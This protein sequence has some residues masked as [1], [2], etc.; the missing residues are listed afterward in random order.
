MKRKIILFLIPAFLICFIYGCSSN[1]ESKSTIN[2]T[3]TAKDTSNSTS[4]LT[5]IMIDI[6][7]G[8]GSDYIKRDT[9]DSSKILSIIREDH[10]WYEVEC[11]SYGR[12]YVKKDMITDADDSEIPLVTSNIKQGPNIRP[13]IAQFNL[14]YML[15]GGIDL[16]SSPKKS[17][18]YQ[19]ID[20]G[21]YVYIINIEP[22]DTHDISDKINIYY[23]IEVTT[24]AGKERAYV[25][26]RDLLD[27]DNPLRNFDKVKN[28]YATVI[29]NNQKYY[30]ATGAHIDGYLNNWKLKNSI[31]ISEENWNI[32]GGITSVI[33]GNTYT[34]ESIGVYSGKLIMPTIQKGKKTII[35]LLQKLIL[36]EGFLQQR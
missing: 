27:Y 25:T 19:T 3:D 24:K 34:D 26:E 21:N 35:K 17:E 16:F 4:N 14:K 12:S 33:S 22:Y 5:G 7:A 30:S 2:P 6:Y 9:I 23:Q 15:T 1:N 11:T 10:G 31:D 29:Y 36:Q 28:N 18:K 20:A 8:P 32:I 13:Q